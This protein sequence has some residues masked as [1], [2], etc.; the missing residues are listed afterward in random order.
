MLAKKPH[1]SLTEKL[2]NIAFDLG[3]CSNR[4]GDTPGSGV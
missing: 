1:D 2:K 3:M 4:D